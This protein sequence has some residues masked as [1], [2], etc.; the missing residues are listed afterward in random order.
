MSSF[1][2]D[3]EIKFINVFDAA[4]I[5]VPDKNDTLIS[6]IQAEFNKLSSVMSLHAGITL[7]TTFLEYNSKNYKITL[8][9][10]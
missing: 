7:M 10:L 9:K 8:E 5:N 3:Y 2:F 4:L 1:N 6:L